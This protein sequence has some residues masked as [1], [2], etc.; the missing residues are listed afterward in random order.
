MQGEAWAGGN[1]WHPGTE[2]RGPVWSLGVEVEGRV[3]QGTVAAAAGSRSS[4]QL[5]DC[6]PD[7]VHLAVLVCIRLVALVAAV[8][9]HL[10][11]AELAAAAAPSEI[12]VERHSTTLCAHDS[13]KTAEPAMS[14]CAS[15]LGAGGSRKYRRMRRHAARPEHGREDAPEV[16]HMGGNSYAGPL[17]LPCLQYQKRPSTTQA[18]KT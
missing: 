1:P 5:Q 2:E 11:P 17:D 18:A 3:V 4:S 7:S 6:M 13:A 15:G 10:A 16:G 12:G 9:I 14:L 8:G